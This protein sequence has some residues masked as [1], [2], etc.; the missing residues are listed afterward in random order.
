VEALHILYYV[1]SVIISRVPRYQD[2]AD[3]KEPV[4]S[5][6][7]IGRYSKEESEAVAN[8]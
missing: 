1:L 7:N 4:V 5:W 3:S 6:S 8:L 2:S